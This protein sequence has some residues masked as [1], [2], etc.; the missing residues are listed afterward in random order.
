M[1]V[2]FDNQ[3]IRKLS[4]EEGDLD[5]DILLDDATS[6]ITFNWSSLLEVLNQGDLFKDFPNFNQE[7]E[8]FQFYITTLTSKS[9][10]E[11]CFHLYD[12]LFAECLKQV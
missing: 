8:L 5:A 6:K 3:I 9:D 12:N 1:H 10:K 4:R 2:F 11:T 7:H